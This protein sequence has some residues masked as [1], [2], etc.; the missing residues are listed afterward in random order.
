MRSAASRARGYPTLTG[1]GVTVGVL[2]D[3]FNCYAVYA[4]PGSGVPVSGNRVTRP[5]AL[6]PTT[7]TDV[8]TRRSAVRRER[9]GGALHIHAL[10]ARRLHWTTARRIRLP[11]TDEG[12]AMLQIVHAV[13]P[14]ASLAF[15]TGDDSEADFANGIGAL[16][17]AGAKVIADDLGYFDEPFF[18]D[19]IVAQAIDTVEAQ[20]VAYFSAAG[21]DANSVL[22]EHGAEL[23]DAGHE[24]LRT[25]ANLC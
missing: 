9:A 18:Q 13:A 11:F 17:G 15:Y 16:A 14:G 7:P 23:P 22:G 5:T 21:N 8:S 19:G 2:S 25:R 10:G 20:G 4:Q 1:A 6:P 12:R 3:S 24:R